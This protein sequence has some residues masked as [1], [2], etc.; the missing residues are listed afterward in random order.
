MSI[1]SLELWAT[2]SISSEQT[3]QIKRSLKAKYDDTAWVEVSTQVYNI[4]RTRLRDAMAGYLLQKPEVKA[5]GLKDTNDLYGYFLMDVEMDACMLTSRL[6]QA[7]A[8]V[9]QFVHRC[10]LN[11]E[12][13]PPGN[14]SPSL[15]DKIHWKSMRLYQLTV[16]SKKVF[17]CPENYIEPELRDNKS[18]FFKELESELLQGEVT[19]DSVEKALVNYLE[20][21]HD[22]ARLDICGTY[23]DTEA[24]ELHVFGRSFN[25]PPQYYYRKRNLKTQVWTAWD[26]VQLDIQGTEE[27]D[28]AGV[29]L[30]PVVWNR[31]L[32]LFWPLFSEKSDKT[33]VLW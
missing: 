28:S 7:I 11:L 32:Y 29:H 30:I 5:L 24:Q 14:L 21:L 19:N 2:D 20:K 18:P 17:I 31:R 13:K 22:V 23:E 16:A 25:N 4:V 10:L 27:G 26:R 9:Q 33:Y 12:S 3:L 6:V 15:I 1:E 8:S